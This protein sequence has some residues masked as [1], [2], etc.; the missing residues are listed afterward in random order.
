MVGGNVSFKFEI[1]DIFMVGGVFNFGFVL[2][3]MLFVDYY[4]IKVKGFI[5][6]LMVLVIFENCFVSCGVV[7]ECV[8][9][10]WLLLN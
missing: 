4:K 2:G 3:F 8:L 5:V 7:L 6:I 10:E 1:G 9:I